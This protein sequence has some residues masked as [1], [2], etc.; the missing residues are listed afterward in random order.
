MDNFLDEEVSVFHFCWHD[1]WPLRDFLFM[2][3]VGEEDRQT[4]VERYRQ[5]YQK[6]GEA[7][8]GLQRC[9]LPYLKN[10]T[11]CCTITGIF[12]RQGGQYYNASS[13]G[14]IGIIINA[15]DNPTLDMASVKEQLK[16]VDGILYISLSAEGDGLMLI[17]RLLHPDNR[18]SQVKRL[19]RDLKKRGIIIDDQ[20]NRDDCFFPLTYDPDPYINEDAIPYDMTDGKSKKRQNEWPSTR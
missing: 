15:D 18:Q 11:P 3:S 16:T 13:S 2:E 1:V 4:F 7:G 19:A 10:K 12:K 8:R 17:I 20:T 9:Y 5:D 6:K 14:L